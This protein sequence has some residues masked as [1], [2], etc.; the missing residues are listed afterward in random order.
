MT[1]W[2]KQ[3]DQQSVLDEVETS[4]EVYVENNYEDVPSDL[5]QLKKMCK[6]K[7]AEWKKKM[8]GDITQEQ[9]DDLISERITDVKQ[10]IRQTLWK[11]CSFSES[12]KSCRREKIM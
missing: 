9:K 4:Y 8:S 6:E 1:E 11:Q 2:A 3:D 12:V 5:K 7:K 10:F